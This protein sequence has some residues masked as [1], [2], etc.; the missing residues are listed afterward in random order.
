MQVF[1]KING[2]KEGGIQ[3]SET[4][5]TQ[6]D[7]VTLDGTLYR[8]SVIKRQLSV[9]LLELLDIRWYQ[10]SAALAQ[11]PVS[12]HYIDDDFGEVVKRFH[13]TSKSAGARCV[14]GGNTYFSGAAFALEEV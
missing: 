11:R 13:V 1:M 14:V 6:R 4:A 12:V 3:Q 8:G 9:Q 5:R 2:F 7:I 10:I